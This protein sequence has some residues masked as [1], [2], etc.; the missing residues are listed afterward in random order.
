[1]NIF[2]ENI[3]A[4]YRDWLHSLGTRSAVKISKVFTTSINR[5][6]KTG[7]YFDPNYQGPPTPVHNLVI[8]LRFLDK[9]SSSRKEGEASLKEAGTDINWQIIGPIIA[10][11]ALVL[12]ALLILLVCCLRKKY[13]E[14][15]Q[16]ESIMGQMKDKV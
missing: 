12:L 13:R 8:Y 7:S 5:V 2:F 16:Q 3:S 6:C 10:V 1:M 11:V 9:V 14:V 15:P 4:I